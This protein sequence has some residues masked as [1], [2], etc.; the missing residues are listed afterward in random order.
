[1]LYLFQYVFA[2]RFALKLFYVRAI[3]RSGDCSGASLKVPSE[4][5]FHYFFT[6]SAPALRLRPEGTAFKFALQKYCF[7]LIYANIFSFCTQFVTS[8]ASVSQ[9][10]EQP[11]V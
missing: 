2:Q 7:F 9:K 1:M 10:K 4:A 8:V 11:I 5:L 6:L 3:P